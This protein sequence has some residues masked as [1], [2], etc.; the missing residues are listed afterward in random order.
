M[1]T[2]E[3]VKDNPLYTLVHNAG[4]VGLIEY[5]GSDKTICESARVSYGNNEKIYSKE[6]D[7]NLIRYMMRHRHTSVFEMAVL[8]F[9]I[10]LP[11]FVMR[12]LIRHR[13]ASV[14][15]MSGR[16]SVMSDEFYLPEL[17]YIQPQ[18]DTNKQGRSDA[19]WHDKYKESMRN[20]IDTSC[21]T[22]Y[23]MYTDLLGYPNSKFTEGLTKELA[24]VVLPV[25]NYTECYWKMDLHNLFHLL[26]LRLDLHAQVE[27]RDYAEAMYDFVKAYFPLSSEAFQDYVL[28]SRTLSRMDIQMLSD[29][30]TFGIIG[31]AEDYE[32]SKREYEEMKEFIRN[33]R[34]RS[35]P[36]YITKISGE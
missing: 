13:M 6:K 4:F 5:M 34:Q 15:E 29:N 23:T 7:R 10:K 18:S 27:I 32:M 12:Q 17:E 11:I 21:M 19:K 2:Q 28:L 24:R 25:A 35:V 14:N 3:Q 31:E 30:D 9:H 36:E 22:S 33:L 20:R 26:K 1:T 16:F 8:K